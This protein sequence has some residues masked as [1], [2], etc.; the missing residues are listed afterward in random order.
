MLLVVAILA[1][2]FF[3]FAVGMA[4]LKTVC[5]CGVCGFR[6]MY[7]QATPSVSVHFLLPVD[8]DVGL[9]AHSPALLLAHFHVP[10]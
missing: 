1:G 6:P 7:A 3:F 5:H 8:Q 9:S 10:P 2:I 4:L